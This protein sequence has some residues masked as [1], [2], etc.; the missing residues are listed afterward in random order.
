MSSTYLDKELK[1][2]QA[3]EKQAYMHLRRQFGLG[4]PIPE[5]AEQDTSSTSIPPPPIPP[6]NP[7]RGTH[8][9][10]P[11]N[12]KDCRARIDLPLGKNSTSQEQQAPQQDVCVGSFT[13]DAILKTPSSRNPATS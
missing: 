2:V 13:T 3:R 4:T 6:H 11:T 7:A 1:T 9:A 10:Y 5:E 12:P 8:Y